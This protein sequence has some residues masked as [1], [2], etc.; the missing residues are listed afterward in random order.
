MEDDIPRDVN[1]IC[2]GIQTP[3]TLMMH[4]LPKKHTEKSEVTIYLCCKG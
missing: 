2:D 1:S 4:T 3:I